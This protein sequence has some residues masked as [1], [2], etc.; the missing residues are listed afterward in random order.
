MIIYL[1]VSLNCIIGF[2]ELDDVLE[3]N[4]NPELGEIDQLCIRWPPVELFE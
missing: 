3:I 1:P 2:A 4:K